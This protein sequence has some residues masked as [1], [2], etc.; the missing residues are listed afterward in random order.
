MRKIKFIGADGSMD[1]RKNQIYPMYSFSY[2]RPQNVYETVIDGRTIY[3]FSL[4]G[5][6][7]NWVEV[8]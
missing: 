8:L 6:L 2:N 4:A 7:D 3:Y 1:F 5:F